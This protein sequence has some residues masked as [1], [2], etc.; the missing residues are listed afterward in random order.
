M[1]QSATVPRDPSTQPSKNLTTSVAALNAKLNA[2]KNVLSTEVALKMGGGATVDAMLPRFVGTVTCYVDD[3]TGD[4]VGLQLG[5]SAPL[6]STAGAPR[7][8][9]VP[10]DG[11]IAD[12][13]VAV[14]KATGL[15][16]E[17]AFVVKSNASMVPTNVVTCGTRG[18]LG[19][20]VMPKLAALAGAMAP[21]C[22]CTPADRPVLDPAGLNGRVTTINAPPAYPTSPTPA[23][24]YVTAN[25]NNIGSVYKCPLSPPIDLDNGCVATT[26]FTR[27]LAAIAVSGWYV[28]AVDTDSSVYACPVWAQNGELPTTSSG[29]VVSTSYGGGIQ[30]SIGAPNGIAVSGGYAYVTTKNSWGSGGVYACPVSGQTGALPTTSAG[31]TTTSGFQDLQ[32]IAVS[33]GYAYLATARGLLYVCPVS[34]QT[35]ALPTTS[36]GCVTSSGFTQLDAISVSG[37]NAY[38]TGFDAALAESFVYVCPVS[39]R[40]GALP[41]TS[42][43]CVRSSALDNS[44]TRL[45]GIAVSATER[46]GNGGNGGLGGPGGNVWVGSNQWS[47]AVGDASGHVYVTGGT[48][49]RTFVCTVSSL[50]NGAVDCVV[51]GNSPTPTGV[52]LGWNNL[53]TTFMTVG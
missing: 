41:T 12:I 36:A 45:S 53:G 44:S 13:K 47:P 15:V 43:G 27:P 28:Y 9:T 10:A 2:T 51:E 31:C 21:A 50:T 39:G 11:Y 3:A 32:G 26:G 23:Y 18:G 14:D 38:V 22:K 25:S 49:G 8:F 4:V 33:G 40:T 42:A 34:C 35:G 48:T 1:R 6:C 46:G 20:S 17:L 37:G 16:G 30:S 52:G 5:S 29:C 7:S 24:T 19:V